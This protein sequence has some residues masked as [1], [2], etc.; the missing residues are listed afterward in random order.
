[1]IGMSLDKNGF[2]FDHTPQK[3]FE[4]RLR[5][6]ENLMNTNVQETLKKIKMLES[7]G[8][9]EEAKRLRQSIQSING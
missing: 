4:A 6:K 2:G 3:A 7:E 1:M 9:Y 5:N 8:K